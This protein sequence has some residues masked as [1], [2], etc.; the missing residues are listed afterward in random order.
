M[1]AKLLSHLHCKRWT[2]NMESDSDDMMFLTQN[3]F[4]DSDTDSEFDTNAHAVNLLLDLSP[5]KKE[6]YKPVVSD[7]S[8]A[9]CEIKE[10]YQPIVSDISDEDLLKATNAI[11]EL[12]NLNK[13]ST[14]TSRPTSRFAKPV[15]DAEMA[16]IGRRRLVSCLIFNSL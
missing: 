1:I 5:K 9:E 13:A 10:I 14:S 8:D 12:E 7:I 6:S 3:S 16:N 4:R 15:D 11:E 2:V